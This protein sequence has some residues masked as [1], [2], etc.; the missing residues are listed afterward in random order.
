MLDFM[1]AI[2]PV[3]IIFILDAILYSISSF[4]IACSYKAVPYRI[5][6][7][8]KIGKDLKVTNK[9]IDTFTSELLKTSVMPRRM[10]L[11]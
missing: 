10:L 11:G 6:R 2:Y 8:D 3:Y 5:A 7:Q 4:L 9:K 1:S